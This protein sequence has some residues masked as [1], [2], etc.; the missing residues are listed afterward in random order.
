[1]LIA[2]KKKTMAAQLLEICDNFKHMWSRIR[3]FNKP[4]TWQSISILV[5]ITWIQDSVGA[6]E[7]ILICRS[8]GNTQL[9][10]REKEQKKQNKGRS[11]REKGKQETMNSNYMVREKVVKAKAR[12]WRLLSEKPE[13]R[14]NVLL[15]LLS[16]GNEL[17]GQV[18]SIAVMTLL[19]NFCSRSI[20]EDGQ[21]W[22]TPKENSSSQRY[23]AIWS[24][25]IAV[26][27]DF[28]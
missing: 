3:S 6:G 25:T 16:G 24:H 7:V 8:S 28:D 2:K 10:K 21:N 17:T 20:H 14:R 5:N 19:K 9:R 15:C 4:R 23:R 11:Q 27:N 22:R 1:M 12:R 13:S 18:L 26:I